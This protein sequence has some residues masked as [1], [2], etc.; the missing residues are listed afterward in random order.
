[1]SEYD[2]LAAAAESA[3]S[4]IFWYGAASREEVDRLEEILSAALPSSFKRFLESYG[5]GGI[6]TAEVSGIENNDAT[7]KNGGTVLGDTLI[8]R[9]RF[10]IPRNLV[11]IYYHDDEV[12]WC[13]NLSE[14]NNGEAPVVAYD[15]FGRKVDRKI[16]ESF[17]EFMR[18][19]LMLYS[20]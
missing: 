6:V 3:G 15:V 7:L 5:G 1:M 8:C 10:E 20:K 11:V 16:A 14:W 13:L 9:E 4:E 17:D 2:D 19:H 18:Q 12:C